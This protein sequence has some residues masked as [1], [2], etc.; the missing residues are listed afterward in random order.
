MGRITLGIALILGLSGQVSAQ[1]VADTASPIQQKVGDGKRMM[2][3]FIRHDQSKNLKEINRTIKKNGYFDQ[4]PPKGVEVVS[5]Y[6]AMGIG[7]IITNN[8][9][10]LR[11]ELV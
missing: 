5:W 3:V 2:T 4:F 10:D 7:Q 1:V 6:V 9:V 11:Q 8:M